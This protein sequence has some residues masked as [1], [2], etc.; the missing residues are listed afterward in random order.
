MLGRPD[1]ALPPAAKFEGAGLGSYEEARWPPAQGNQQGPR[2]VA[3]HHAAF[4]AELPQNIRSLKQ[5]RSPY[6]EG[7]GGFKQAAQSEFDGVMV[8]P[9]GAER[10]PFRKVSA[11]IAKY[12]TARVMVLRVV[13]PFKCK[14]DSDGNPS[15]RAMRISVAQTK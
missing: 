3:G 13:V 1:S 14:V 5:A 6:W 10:V 8:K 9:R 11:A 15:K 2:N 4:G 7:S 12:G